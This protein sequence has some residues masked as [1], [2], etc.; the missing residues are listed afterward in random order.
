M[1]MEVTQKF[2]PG[3]TFPLT[4]QFLHA[5]EVTLT[6]PVDNLRRSDPTEGPTAYDATSSGGVSGPT[7]PAAP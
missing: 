6:V 5:G 7:D 3:D 1:L 4:L 2:K